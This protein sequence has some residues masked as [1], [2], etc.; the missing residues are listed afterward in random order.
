MRGIGIAPTSRKDSAPL[1]PTLA[2]VAALLVSVALLLMGNGLQGTLLPVR[3]SIEAFTTLDIGLIGTAYYAG[4]ATGCAFGGRLVARAGHIRTF[5]AMAAIA[6]AVPLVH[7]MVLMPWAW[8]LF[9]AVTGFCFAVLYVVIESWLNE[10]STNETRGLILSF[11]TIINLTVMT[12]GQMMLT[13]D[14]P[15]NF[16][17]FALASI[18]VSLA[19]VPV[20]MTAAAAPAPVANVRLRV[21]RL[22][23]ISPVGF[24][25]VLTVGLANGAFWALGPIF[26]QDSGLNITGI[27]LFM[28]TAVIAGALGQWP[29][30]R[31]S[32]LT[33]RRRI[34][35]AACVFASAS[36]IAMALLNEHWTYGILL[37]AFAFGTFAF[38][39]Y[40]V[41]VAHANDHVSAEEFVETSS[42]LLLVFAAGAV[43]GPLPAAFLMARI[44]TDGL[45]LYTAVIHALMAVFTVYRMVHREAPVDLQKDDFISLPRTSPTVFALDPRSGADDGQSTETADPGATGASGA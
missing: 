2:P 4:F 18:L 22:Y 23:R 39:L 14:D 26:A 7:A 31:A 20:A 38:P 12:I 36:G 40:A 43:I 19:A 11:Y 24:A 3:G 44:G 5:A 32:D 33:D 25:A 16:T 35:L 1:A 9:R 29:L 17:L 28:S 8:W 30:G 15:A 42:G 27:A 13:L 6:S 37:F 45:F 21:F 10:R 41:A 34:I